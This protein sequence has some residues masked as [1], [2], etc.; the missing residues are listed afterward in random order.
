MEHGRQAIIVI[1]DISARRH[2]LVRLQCCFMT[3]KDVGG[4]AGVVVPTAAVFDL[5]YCI[6]KF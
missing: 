2:R 6:I 3:L 4:R 1:C 5:V